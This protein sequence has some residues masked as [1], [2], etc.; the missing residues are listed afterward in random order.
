MTD[1]PSQ[2]SQSAPSTQP[3]RKELR[4]FDYSPY[5]RYSKVNMPDLLRRIDA[6]GHQLQ[7]LTEFAMQSGAAVATPDP[8]QLDLFEADVGPSLSDEEVAK[9][10]QEAE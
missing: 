2:T 8:K 7:A 4:R 9:L 3:R 5:N 10:E 6:F 1:Q